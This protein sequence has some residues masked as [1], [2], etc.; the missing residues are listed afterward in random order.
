MRAA[1]SI[2]PLLL[3]ST[4]I[5]QENAFAAWPAPLTVTPGRGAVAADNVDASRAGAEVLAAGGNAVD[6]AVAASLALGVVAPSGSGLG[7]G[8]FLVLWR[9]AEKKVY[10][11]DYR[12]TA[13]RAARKEL[14]VVDGK[15]DPER[16]RT[17]GL[18]VAVPGQP[19]GLAEAETRFGKLGLARAAAPAV[20]LARDGFVA[21]SLLG[22]LAPRMLARF[23][24]AVDDS[25]R[26]LLA[27]AGRPLS[28]GARVTRPELAATLEAYAKGGAAALTA[29]PIA[30]AMV[31]AVQRRGGNLTD[32]DL[33]SY[34]PIWRAPVEGTFRNRKLYGAPPPAGDAT[35]IEALQILDARPPAPRGSSAEL[36]QIVEALKH[37]FADRARLLG[38]PAFT[39]IPLAQLLDPGYTRALAAK[40]LDEKIQPHDAYGQPAA[41]PRDH[42]T[43]HVCAVD[44]EGNVV[45]ITNTINLPFGA[46]VVAGGI[47]LNDEMDDFA[48][49]PNAPNAYRLVGGDANAIAPGKRPASSMSPLIV[50][51][52]DRAVMC[53][54]GSGGPTIVSGVV[55]VIVNAI[56]HHLDAEAA[57]AAPRVHAQWIP[58]GV[59]AE[60]DIPS[61]VLDGL[62]RRGHQVI[63]FLE[64]AIPAV[65]AILVGKDGVQA[66][67][68]PRK[69]GAPAAP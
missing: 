25:L 37:A 26:A 68:D 64:H 9:A 62:R 43:S 53:V 13:P 12:E 14:F 8:G 60:P 11:L 27:P 38:D 63:P 10:V 21:S 16:S 32:E 55:Q 23:G 5:R 31:T 7:G 3:I 44:G 2:L 34:R 45:A 47:L 17:G 39:K 48:A 66:A 24:A 41:P 29:G 67:S 4:V 59:M 46:G 35:A 57:V 42:G 15:V 28:A 58:D 49:D 19:A 18:A 51:D 61:D 56:D 36:H 33:A 30:R 54:G 40:I 6:A 65:Q 52:G 50:V 22:V 1:L 69:G 20:R